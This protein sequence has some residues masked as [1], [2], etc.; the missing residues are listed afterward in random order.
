M[1]S[2]LFRKEVFDAQK[3]NWTG[4]I[5]LT[6]PVSFTFLTCCALAVGLVLVAFAI[7]GEY[8]KRSTVKGQLIPQS[9]LVQV[10]ALQQGIISEKY[11]FEGKTVQA[12]EALYKISLTR[13]TENGD[14]AQA[15]Q[16][17]IKLKEQTLR[18]EIARNQQVHQQEKQS[19][20]NQIQRLKN[21]ILQLDGQ[22]N[23]QHQRIDLAENNVKRYSSAY[24][25]NI[26]SQEELEYRKAEVFSQNE[27]L[28]TLKR[29]KQNLEKQLKEQEI[30]LQRLNAQYQ[31]QQAQFQRALVNNQQ[32]LIENQAQ[33][34]IIIKANTSGTVSTV[35]AD[36]GQVVDNNK[37]LLSIL[38]QDN[39]LIAQLY[40]PSRAIGFIKTG[41][42]VL[43]RYQAYPYQKFGHAQAEIIS[44]AKTAL[45][46]QNLPTIGTVSLTEQMN[47]EP[48]Y[49]VRAK[50]EK[51][52]IQ[53][54]GEHMPL[55]VGMMLEG[56]ILHETRKLY[57]W[58]LEP[59]Y[60][61]TGKI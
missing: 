36:I 39:I 57:E 47:N 22:I 45:A 53:A 40:V 27:K 11:V 48:L 50:L 1:M 55:Q 43:L 4:S 32:E 8:T 29:E 54:Y 25:E 60:S 42:N 51:Q 31:V 16:Q 2:N 19:T 49:I 33:Q 28:T 6:R 30:N 21:D 24:Q 61:I 15:L 38:P 59:L 14:I 20:E 44:V 35:N 17:Q 37:P 3:V 7:W 41:D 12:G 34:S 56:D 26:V 9:G 13:H 23:A 52:H 10:Y 5:I 46:G 18:Q 58:V